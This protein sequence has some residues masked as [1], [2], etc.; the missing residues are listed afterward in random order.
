MYVV[1]N[2]YYSTFYDIV[3]YMT[4]TYMCTHVCTYMYVHCVH[5]LHTTYITCVHTA[6]LRTY[7]HESLIT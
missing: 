7:I 2:L 5:I 6:V 3:T 1:R 4:Y